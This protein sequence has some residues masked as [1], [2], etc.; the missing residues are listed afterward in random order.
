MIP[1]SDIWLKWMKNKLSIIYTTKTH[2]KFTNC[3]K[4]LKTL[5]CLGTEALKHV[6]V[7]KTYVHS[8]FLYPTTEQS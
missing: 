2:N 1:M 4:V 6:E 8:H 3:T 5:T 7:Y